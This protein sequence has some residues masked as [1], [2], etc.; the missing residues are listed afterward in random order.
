[1]MK[2]LYYFFFAFFWW[3][4]CVAQNYVPLQITSGFNEDVIAEDSLA[5]NF[6]TISIDN[7]NSSDSN[8]VLMS[9]NY[10]GATVGL[11]SNRIITS[12]ITN[13]LSFQLAPYNV[14][15]AL[16]I[17]SGVDSGTLVFQNTLKISKLFILATSGSGKS[18]FEGTIFFTDGTI[19][20]INK[21]QVQDWY[22]ADPS[23]TTISGLGRVSRYNKGLP[24]NNLNNPKLFQFEINIDVTNENKVIKEVS[25]KTLSSSIGYLNV[26]AVSAEKTL[27]IT[28]SQT[29]VS[30]H[31]GSNGSATVTVTGGTGAY[32][33]LWSN[34]ASTAR[35]T[36]LKAGDYTVTVTDANGCTKTEKVT[37]TEPNKVAPPK[38]STPIIYNY[39]D[40]AQPLT[41]EA[42]IGNTLLWY[43][44]ATGTTGSSNVPIP[45]T[46]TVGFQNY[47]V[48]QVNTIGCESDRE[49][50]TVQVKK[51]SL[52]VTAHPQTKVYGDIDPV[53]TYAVV[54]LKKGETAA[55]VLT[56]SLV[57]DAGENTGVYTI[58]QGNLQV[59][60]NYVLTYKKGELQITAAP[61]QITPLKG[62]T[63]VYGQKDAVLQ[64][65]A[66]GFKFADTVAVL[67]GTLGR[68]VGE[69]VGVYAYTVGSLQSLF[70]NYKMTIVPGAQYTITPAG[71]IVKVN[72]NQN[73][74]YG[75]KDPVFTYQVSGM[76]FSESAYYAV[77]GALSRQQGEDVGL[78]AIEQGSLIAR[79]NYVITSFVSADFEIKKAKIQGLRLPSET[80][81]YDGQPKSLKVVGD[82]PVEAVVTYTNNG[83]V[84]VGK[85]AVFATV[86]YGKN[87]EVLQLNGELFIEQATQQITFAALTKVVLEDTPTLQ[88]TAKASSNLP[89]TYT[90]DSQEPVN[91]AT[92]DS[93]TGV[94]TFIQPGKIV[95]TA[96]Q[97]GN[98]N[99]KAAQPV[100]QTIEITSRDAS[101]WDL[102]IDGV[103]YG[104]VGAEVYVSI[105]CDKPQDVVVIEVKTQYGAVVVPSALIEVNVKEYGIHQQLITVTSMDGTVSKTYKVIIEKRIP[106]EHIVFQKYDN[107][108][109]VNKN[110]STNGGYL[111][112]GYQWYRNGEVISKKQTYSAGG[113]VGAI[114]DA[115]AEY[116]VELT[117][118]DGRKIVSCPIVIASKSK[119]GL[120]VYPN[121]VNKS[122]HTQL[123]VRSQRKI[124]Q[125]TYS[126]YTLLGQRIAQGELSGENMAI[127][128]PNTIASGSYFLVLKG[129]DVSET[130]QFIVKE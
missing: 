25:L 29:N 20:A 56:G 87:Y 110:T 13:G 27:Q 122:I 35:I 46:N 123:Y 24:D 82:M 53:L 54:G 105:G 86:D 60:G 126:V 15:N 40:V 94:L 119:A 31:G 14:N 50:I 118:Y 30:C 61:L 47:W 112:T 62:Q 83:Q 63:K 17:Y 66:Q 34:G 100:S 5:V 52:T 64:Y 109:L 48:S 93:K 115:G 97:E 33:Y 4:M 80:F 9:I 26:F 36:G 1:M 104:K 45:D 89:I 121:P 103:S 42:N 12:K 23:K 117:L 18:D 81:V 55:T 2:Q 99:Y 108:L 41:A 32:T 68:Q 84:N 10:P 7:P 49:L 113:E 22:D 92:I 71:L 73:K 19:Q 51:A 114:L 111:F 96:H 16:R 124:T 77:T 69:Q 65:T 88:L 6:T 79:A 28:T 21:Q 74:I 106:T 58:Q 98:V 11:P 107:I 102:L 101:I 3:S 78:Y 129:E 72:T 116:H 120:V 70:G 8:T 67:S 59:N 43:T 95:V 130:V 127:S 44:T 37:I 90:I 125:G 128:L 85:Y 75:T 76:Q 91:V 57:R 39:G 38:V